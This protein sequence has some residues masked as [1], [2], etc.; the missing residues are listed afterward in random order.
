VALEAEVRE[1]VLEKRKVLGKETI[2]AVP[3]MYR[4]VEEERTDNGTTRRGPLRR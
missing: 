3:K 4:P 1:E 2:F